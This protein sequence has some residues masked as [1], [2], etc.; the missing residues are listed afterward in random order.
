MLLLK[1]LFHLEGA[2]VLK[3][4]SDVL[5]LNLQIT[6]TRIEGANRWLRRLMWLLHK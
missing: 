6:K 3:L 1:Y 5:K 2:N 4:T